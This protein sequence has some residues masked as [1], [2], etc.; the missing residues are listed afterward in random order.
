MTTVT[1]NNDQARFNM[2]EQQIRPWNVLDPEVLQ[3]LGMLRARILYRQRI[4]PWLFA[5]IE[6]PLLPNA[7]PEQHM[8]TPCPEAHMF[9]ALALGAQYRYS[10]G[11]W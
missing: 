10:A 11:G 4:A 8:L 5:D 2:I 7:G 6:I 1:M 9:Q 3:H